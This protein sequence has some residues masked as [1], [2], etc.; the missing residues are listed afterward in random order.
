[1]KDGAW[2]IRRFTPGCGEHDSWEQDAA[3]WTKSFLNK[4]PD[5]KTAAKACDAVEDQKG[6]FNFEEA[7]VAAK[8]LR[9]LGLTVEVPRKLAMEP[10]KLSKHK[11]GRIVV[12]VEAGKS[13]EA[14][15]GEMKGWLFE[16]GNFIKIFSAKNQALDEPKG[17]L[18]DDSIRFLVDPTEGL[19]EV[20]WF[21]Y[22][23]ELQ[24]WVNLAA[25]NLKM[26]LKHLG[27]NAKE[28]DE[29][30][31]ASIS[32]PWRAVVEPFQPEYPGQ[33]S[34]NRNGARLRYQ[35][36]TGDSFNTPTWDMIFEHLGK[37][38]ND[39]V[40]KNAWCRDNGIV[41]GA[42]YLRVWCASLFQ[43]PKQPL[44][45]LFFYSAAQN[46]GKSTLGNALALLMTRGVVKAA[47]CLDHKS[48][49][50]GELDG[51]VLCLVEE[52]ELNK[53]PSVYNRLKDWVTSP[54]LGIHPKGG[55]PYTTINTT[56]WIHTA[57]DHK[58]CPI[59][60]GDTRI[61]AISVSPLPKDSEIPQEI[62]LHKLEEESPQFLGHMFAIELP[63]PISRL[64]V[65]CIDTYQK[66]AI[67]QSTTTPMQV[68]INTCCEVRLGVATR[69]KSLLA[70]FH[71]WLGDEDDI[72]KYTITQWHKE[73]PPLHQKGLVTWEGGNW[74]PNLVLQAD[75][76][77]IIRDD[78]V[79]VVK[80]GTMLI[81]NDKG[82][83]EIKE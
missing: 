27:L 3:G 78:A 51:A 14:L 54:T 47:T 34:W 33:R 67:M 83:L 16:K 43:K 40:R 82:L 21:S 2:S 56:H 18:Y 66:S 79:R 53:S 32:R 31:G 77:L 41:T 6:N 13:G 80:E 63:D 7:E 49:F 46:T 10:T 15:K 36:E 62:L 25:S 42:D 59:W 22:S 28:T 44:P 1:M 9:M 60:P 45:Y 12:T 11:D 69:S 74:V 73:L 23:E 55:T 39:S 50:N 68:F 70:A 52:A 24:G 29:A 8:A 30:M 5:L 75:S 37:D 19:S 26:Q 72:A 64:A 4:E 65:P 57:N 61:V 76:D 58:Y 38:I 17:Q 81:V 20:G 35:P 48:S 71:Q